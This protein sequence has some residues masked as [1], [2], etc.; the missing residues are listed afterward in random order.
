MSY[1]PYIKP[2]TNAF[3]D[4]VL[5][6]PRFSKFAVFLIKLLGRPYLYLINSLAKIVL[7]RE[8]ILF[9]IFK[10]SLAGEGR[11]IIAFRHPYDSE[12]QI[13]TWFFLF[14]LK[15]LAKRKGV[16]FAIKA[17]ARFIYTYEIARWG[18]FWARFIMP[19]I[20]A[21]PIHHNKIDSNGMARIY[22][23]IIDGPYP[24]ALAPE[25]QVSYSADTVPRLEQGVIRIG[26]NSA[27]KLSELGSDMQ[28]NIVPLSIHF[29]YGRKAKFAMEKLLLKM[30]KLCG[31][32]SN[33]GLA[34]LERVRLCRDYILELNEKFY[35]IAPNELPFEQRLEKLMDTALEKGERM[36]G[37]KSYGDFFYRMYRLR[38]HCWDRIFLPNVH[39]LDGL[40]EME[41]NLYDLGAGEAWYIGRHQELIDFCW[42]FRIPLP[43]EHAPLHQQV[44]YIQNLW[45]FA[46]RSMG[47]ALANR[48]HIKPRRILLVPAEP[49]NI[50]ERLDA[51]KNDKKTTIND[52]LKKLEKA[53]LNCIE[54]A[55]R[56]D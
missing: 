18:G 2:V 31:L 16:K 34:F 22:K 50:N 25:G 1:K 4:I 52:T 5:P 47:G 53:F 48:K 39:S 8:D 33:K 27:E 13:L 51:Y 30:E 43:T 41:R 35:G 45:D 15:Q 40:T 56:E 20:G 21:M 10:R 14:K 7:K 36:I 44:E 26:F 32:S 42:Y 12:P 11:Y 29:R 24:L 38:Q 28:I 23:A 55:G 46:S 49:I 9:D 6:E 17:H 54:E 3:S 37:V 19:R